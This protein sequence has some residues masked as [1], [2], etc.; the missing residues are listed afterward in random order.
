MGDLQ[1]VTEKELPELAKLKQLK[2]H[3][4]RKYIIKSHSWA[5]TWAEE[6]WIFLHG[7][8]TQVNII[9]NHT[10]DKEFQEKYKR[11]KFELSER[12][13]FRV[14]ESADEL[15]QREFS[16]FENER[17]DDIERVQ[18]AMTI[19]VEGYKRSQKGQ[20]NIS[21]D[22]VLSTVNIPKDREVEATYSDDEGESHKYI[23]YHEV[24]QKTKKRKYKGYV[25]GDTYE[26]PEIMAG[27]K[28]KYASLGELKKVSFL[29]FYQ[30]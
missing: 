20:K 6:R 2:D 30:E 12:L 16:R 10:L 25:G 4:V 7:L 28:V 13:G 18:R 22:E 24:K 8:R 3:V 23:Q 15:P 9:L 5:T 29:K 27:S 11:S 17:T 14:N 26:Q 21:L 1:G 19:L